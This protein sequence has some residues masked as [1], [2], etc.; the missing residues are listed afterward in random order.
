MPRTR[1]AGRLLVAHDLRRAKA[2]L[3]CVAAKLSPSSTIRRVANWSRA[4]GAG[5]SVP[6]TTRSRMACASLAF[7]G[8]TGMLAAIRAPGLRTRLVSV[9]ARR[10][11]GTNC[12]PWPETAASKLCIGKPKVLDIHQLERSG[13]PGGASRWASSIIPGARSIP[14]TSPP[15]ATAL[16][17]GIAERPGTAGQVEDPLSRAGMDPIDYGGPAMRFAASHD[18][19][20][21]PL[22]GVGDPAEGARV[23]VLGGWLVQIKRAGAKLPPSA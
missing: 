3:F 22:I 14:T 21:A 12:K 4:F 6:L 20:E 23:Q 1:P 7:D 13:R 17:E 8:S 5:G 19:V 18:L 2:G 11:S 15:G 10:R 9:R 16:R